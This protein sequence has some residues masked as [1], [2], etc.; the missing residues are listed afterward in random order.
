MDI[1]VGRHFYDVPGAGLP[2]VGEVHVVLVVEQAQADL[3]P[4]EGPR[5]ELHNAGLLVEGEVSDVNCAGGLQ[6]R[7]QLALS[8]SVHSIQVTFIQTRKMLKK[9]RKNFT[10][11][12]R[13]L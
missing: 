12:E 5:P 7:Y 9:I 8:L 13:N 10:D 4:S 2:V 1:E 11:W 3:V 6:E